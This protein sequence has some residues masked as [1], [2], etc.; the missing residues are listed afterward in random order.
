[1]I[2]YPFIRRFMSCVLLI[3]DSKGKDDIK[4]AHSK[5]LWKNRNTN[6]P[7]KLKMSGRQPLTMRKLPIGIQGFEKFRTEKFVY[8]DKAEYIYDLVH[9]NTPCFLSRP[10]RFGKSFLLSAM[11]A[12]RKEGNFSKV[13][14][15]KS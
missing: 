6:R 4:A 7:A 3:G 2:E 15:W 8:V 9:S 12:Y 13:W 1:M 10:R 5:D 11:R 14:Q